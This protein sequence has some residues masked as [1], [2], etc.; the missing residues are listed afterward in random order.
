MP[1]QATTRTTPITFRRA[2]RDGTGAYQ[3][4]PCNTTPGRPGS[5]NGVPTTAHLGALSCRPCASH[6]A[7]SNT[8]GQD[9]VG[10]VLQQ[11]PVDALGR[12]QEPCCDRLV[13]HFG[14]NIPGLVA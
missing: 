4:G 8:I 10:E 13:T 2:R 5:G 3:H 14:T 11:L 7:R 9:Q 12:L 1:P 6:K